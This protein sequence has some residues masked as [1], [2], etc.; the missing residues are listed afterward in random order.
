VVV[1]VVSVVV[2]VVVVSVGV[3]VGDVVVSVVAGVVVVCVPVFVGVVVVPVAAGV[4]SVGVVV[5][6]AWVVLVWL[7]DW[8]SLRWRARSWRACW[9]AEVVCWPSSVGAP[10]NC[11]ARCGVSDGRPLGTA[12][13]DS[14]P[15]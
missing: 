14:T 10:C 15:A 12:L 2:G 4:V 9:A 6:G 8:A 13:N 5:D 11:F 1:V 3:G 7:F